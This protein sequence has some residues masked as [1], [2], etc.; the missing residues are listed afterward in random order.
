MSVFNNAHQAGDFLL[1]LKIKKK[2]TFYLLSINIGSV[3]LSSTIV[4]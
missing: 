4:A 1:G 3:L 2:L